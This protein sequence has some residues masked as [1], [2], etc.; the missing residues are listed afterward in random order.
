[1][2]GG[3]MESSSGSEYLFF[4]PWYG[5]GN[6]IQ[7]GWSKG[8]TSKIMIKGG[9][10]GVIWLVEISPAFGV[11]NP[12]KKRGLSSLSPSPTRSLS[13]SSLFSSLISVSSCRAVSLSLSLSYSSVVSLLP[14]PSPRLSSFSISLTRGTLFISSSLS[15]VSYIEA[16]ICARTERLLYSPL[17]VEVHGP[18]S[19]PDSGRSIG[20]LSHLRDSPPSS[21]PF[22]R[23]LLLLL[24]VVFF[25]FFLSPSAR[26]RHRLLGQVRVHCM[27]YKCA[28]SPSYLTSKI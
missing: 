14:S 12:R 13:L 3:S 7:W 4:V 18:R 24:Y 1:M 11:H 28:D 8:K 17:F 5:P 2:P 22:R 21:I 26:R 16:H 20:F 23:L 25:L 27:S 19:C 15:F 9:A 6:V 10:R